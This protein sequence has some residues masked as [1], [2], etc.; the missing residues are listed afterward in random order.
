MVLILS[1]T[2]VPKHNSKFP[3]YQ[4]LYL[5]VLRCIDSKLSCTSLEIVKW[6][7]SRSTTVSLGSIAAKFSQCEQLLSKIDWE[8]VKLSKLRWRFG[9]FCHFLD[10][11]D[12]WDNWNGEIWPV[13][14]ST[15]KCMLQQFYCWIFWILFLVSE[16]PY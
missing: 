2:T 9:C 5:Q 12:N 10:N 16:G 3:I 11:W 4:G 1:K 13:E 15:V 8:N 6:Y 7:R 14:N